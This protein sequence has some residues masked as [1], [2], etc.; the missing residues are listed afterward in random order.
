MGFNS[1]FKGLSHISYQV[2][3]PTG[4]RLS[5]HITFDDGHSS[6]KTALF[7][8]I[9]ERAAV[10]PYPCFRTTYWSHFRGSRILDPWR[11]PHHTIKFHRCVCVL[12]TLSEYYMLSRIQW[13]YDY[14]SIKGMMMTG[15]SPSTAPLCLPQI[16]QWLARESNLDLSGGRPITIHM[17]NI[18]KAGYYSPHSPCS[19]K[20]HHTAHISE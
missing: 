7:W 14:K 19:S 4:S 17:L 11:F 15:K 13:I 9:T 20:S 1:G 2:I 18:I 5:G 8:V 12:R 6:L 10:I 16:S 3:T